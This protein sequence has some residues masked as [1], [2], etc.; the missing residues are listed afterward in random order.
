MTRPTHYT[1]HESFY[2]WQGEGIHMGRAAFFI[3][4]QGCDQRCW[5]CD[6]AGTWAP[7]YIPKGMTKVDPEGFAALAADVPEG[8]IVVITGGEPTMY[9]LEPAIDLLHEQGRFVTIETAGH[10]PA[11]QNVDWI[12]LSPKPFAAKPLRETVERADEF[13]I[14][15]SDQASLDDGLALIGHR[16]PMATVWLHPEWGHR[17]NPETLT[18]ISDAVKADPDLRAGWQ[19]HKNYLVDL[20][21]PESRKTPVPLG[22]VDGNPY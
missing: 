18:I 17:A 1:I 12:T 11:P 3:R 10:R 7:G 5:F 16:S 8:A 9:D 6:A 13:K 4:T 19:V 15:V 2:T 22:G 20:M 21:V 14:I